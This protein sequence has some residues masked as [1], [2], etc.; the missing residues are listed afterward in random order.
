MYGEEIQQE[1][2]AEAQ[3][4]CDRRNVR[5]IG[6]YQTDVSNYKANWHSRE[7]AWFK[8]RWPTPPKPEMAW[9]VGMVNNYPV[10]VPTTV[11]VCDELPLPEE[12]EQT[13][14]LETVFGYRVP[15]SWAIPELTGAY[16]G[17]GSTAPLGTR[18][19]HP[20]TGVMHELRQFGT[21]IGKVPL[22]WFPVV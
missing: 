19:A 18:A 15:E 22:F 9:E 3:R 8:G 4:E 20:E 2:I 12:P 11:P 14:E 16:N 1:Q 13:E 7:Q 10:P 5:A 17:A 6:H 21:A